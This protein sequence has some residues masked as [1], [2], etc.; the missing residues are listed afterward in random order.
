MTKLSE[1]NITKDM[2]ISQHCH[3]NNQYHN[4]DERNYYDE[5]TTTNFIICKYCSKM[6]QYRR[7]EEGA[8]AGHLHTCASVKKMK[9]RCCKCGLFEGFKH[10]CR[11]TNRSRRKRL[12]K[13]TKFDG[14]L[15]IFL[16]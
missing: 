1:H 3:Y 6:I 5:S 7:N 13:L 16:Q 11:N 14:M 4:H 15:R 9:L 12:S 8:L 10:N 2:K